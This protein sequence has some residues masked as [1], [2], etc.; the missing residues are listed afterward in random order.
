MNLLARLPEVCA[1]PAVLRV[2]RGC[3]A[4]PRAALDHSPSVAPPQVCALIYRCT[5]FDGKLGKPYDKSV[6]YSANFCQVR[7][8]STPPACLSY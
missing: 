2:P 5:Y 6:D 4:M 7:H 3:S 8:K 1:L